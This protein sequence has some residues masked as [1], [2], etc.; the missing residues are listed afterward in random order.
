[1]QRQRPYVGIAPS[2]LYTNNYSFPSG[3][4]VTA[5]IAATIILAYLGWKWGLASYIVAALIGIS[6]IV[7]DVHY[8]SDVLAGAAIGIVLGGLVMFAAYRLGFYDH[9]DLISR[10]I[11]T[12]KKAKTVPGDNEKI[13]VELRVISGHDRHTD[14]AYTTCIEP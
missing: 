12:K 1:M 10:L 8:P 4:A 5:F 7:L 3:H 14:G 13:F 6:R 11:R 9:P 2:Y